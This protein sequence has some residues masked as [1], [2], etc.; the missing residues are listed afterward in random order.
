MNFQIVLTC[1]SVLNPSGTLVKLAL[2]H[3]TV[4]FPFFHLH[5]Q[6]DGQS[7]GLRD[8]F[9]LNQIKTNVFM[10]Y[11]TKWIISSK[12][13]LRLL[14]LRAILNINYL[15]TFEANAASSVVP[16]NINNQIMAIES[17]NCRLMNEFTIL[18]VIGVV[19]G[20]SIIIVKWFQKTFF[21]VVI[22]SFTSIVSS[23]MC[24]SCGHFS[25]YLILM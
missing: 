15:E 3:S 9:L 22:V 6:K 19:V 7:F 24:V 17:T 5:S 10:S 16:C 25:S 18:F 23:S 21:L 14:P 13:I 4:S 1:I 12:M 2:T 8:A 20:G 11:Q